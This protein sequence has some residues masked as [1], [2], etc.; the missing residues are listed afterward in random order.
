MIKLKPGI[1]LPKLET[2]TLCLPRSGWESDTFPA[3]QLGFPICFWV[4]CSWTD[5]IFF[6]F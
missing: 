3:A 6:K 5:R 2:T 1:L 4:F